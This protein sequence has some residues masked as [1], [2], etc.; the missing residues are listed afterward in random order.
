[1]CDL[2][3]CRAAKSRRADLFWRRLAYAICDARLVL[4]VLNLLRLLMSLTNCSCAYVVLR[5]GNDWHMGPRPVLPVL[6]RAADCWTAVVH[7][8]WIGVGYW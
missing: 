2:A 5:W 1:M 4:S 6:V 7:W 8:E 3:A